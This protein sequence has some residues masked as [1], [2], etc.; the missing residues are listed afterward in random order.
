VIDVSLTDLELE[1]DPL[2]SSPARVESSA[3]GE[4]T[5]PASV[6]VWANDGDVRLR[7]HERE[8]LVALRDAL[9]EALVLLDVE[10]AKEPVAKEPVA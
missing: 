1:E 3:A 9:S 7:F 8:R 2:R 4:Y 5:F 10:L 6:V